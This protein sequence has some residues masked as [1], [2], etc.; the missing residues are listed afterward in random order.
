LI[1][2]YLS[3]FLSKFKVLIICNLILNLLLIQCLNLRS[4]IITK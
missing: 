3:W 1:F 4:L 2:D